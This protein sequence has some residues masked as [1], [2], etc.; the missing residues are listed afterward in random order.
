MAKRGKIFVESDWKKYKSSSKD[1]LALIEEL[2]ED[3][4]TFTIL[5]CYSTRAQVNYGEVEYQIKADVLKKKLYNGE[6]EYYNKNI[7]SRYFRPKDECSAETSKKI[8]D[9]AKINMIG[10][11]N[12]RGSKGISKGKGIPKSG[13]K[14]KGIPS[15]G[16]RAKGSLQTGK[17]AKGVKHP[18]IVCPHCLKSGGACTMPRWHFDNCK[19]KVKDE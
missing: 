8:S 4:F 17:A 16:K 12:G 7:M 11:T 2:G 19:M 14:A 10:N 6:Y 9:K 15:T 1:L 5:E 3:K 18:I 13:L